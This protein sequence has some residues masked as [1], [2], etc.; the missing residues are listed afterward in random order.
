MVKGGREAKCINSQ[1]EEN[2]GKALG[3]VCPRVELWPELVADAEI[4]EFSLSERLR[5]MSGLRAELVA[6]SHGLTPIELNDSLSRVAYVLADS[7]VRSYIDPKV[8]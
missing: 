2:F 7:S 8:S 1:W 4:I 5:P 6:V 3:R